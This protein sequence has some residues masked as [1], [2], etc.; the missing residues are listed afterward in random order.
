MR[1]SPVPD[2]RQVPWQAPRDDEQGIDA[3]VVALAGVARRQALS[4]HCDA[5][6][7]VFVQR[8]SGGFRRTPLLDLDE[9]D[10]APASGHQID[11]AAGNA[12]AAG[13]NAP[14]LQ[15]QPPGGDCFRPAPARLRQLPVQSPPPSSKARA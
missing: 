12:G 10:D 5:A 15:P 6:K 11:F 3:D 1:L 2:V 9:G 14:A 13:K 8:P 4:G 7:A